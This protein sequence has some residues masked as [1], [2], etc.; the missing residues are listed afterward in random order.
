MM[1]RFSMAVALVAAVAMAG[2]AHATTVTWVGGNGTWYVG[3]GVWSTTGGGTGSASSEFGRDSGWRST[4][5]TSSAAAVIDG[6]GS[7]VY[8]NGDVVGDF[9]WRANSNAEGGSVTVSGGATFNM[10]TDVFTDGAWMQFDSERFT[11]TGAGSL[12]NRF[13]T[14]T[15]S[16][17]EGL[18]GGAFIFGSWKGYADPS[19]QNIDVEALDGGEIRNKG[20][21][22]FGAYGD[23][24]LLNATLT[25]GSNAKFSNDGALENGVS[26]DDSAG[27]GNEGEFNFIY[28]APDTAGPHAHNY[29]W[30][31]T[32]DG[33]V[34]DLGVEGI[35]VQVQDGTGAWTSTAVTYEDLWDGVATGLTSDD[36]ILHHDGNNSNNSSAVFDDYFVVSGG[37]LGGSQ[38]E[39]IA[40]ALSGGAAQGDINND[41]GTD[42]ADFGILAGNFGTA[43]PHSTQDGDINW[44]AAS[45]SGGDELVDAADAGVM[46]GGWTGDAPPAGAGEAT[47]TYNPYTGQIEV[48]VNG[49]VNWYVE[50]VGSSIMTGAAPSGLPGGGGLVTDNDTRIGETAFAP[51]AYDVDLGNV[52]ATGYG[53]AV[54]TLKIFWNASLGGALQS[55]AVVIVPEPTSL[56]LAGLA[57]C[58][59]LATRR[60]R[61]A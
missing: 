11:V 2:A 43:G 22:W 39:S 38:L 21:T 16:T 10:E 25:I 31:F 52:A 18:N 42:A 61:L 55:A 4:E 17:S 40:G 20:Q 35:R 15:L 32:G 28:T 34:I 47:A 45:G 19:G 37:S 5:G 30:N 53:G 51:F 12:F 14:A 29:K 24:D 8:Y 58:G 27:A 6:A 44:T 50:N 1:K 48:S 23:E 26:N 7:T 54:D 59:V 33:G 9:R 36:A 13:N 49:V 57:V 3:T 46:F 56:A 41:G 60:R